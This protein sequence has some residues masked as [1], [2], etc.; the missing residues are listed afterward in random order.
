MQKVEKINKKMVI[1]EKVEKYETNDVQVV[2]NSED[3]KIAKRLRTLF[4]KIASSLN[5][6]DQQREEII[7]LIVKNIVKRNKSFEQIYDDTMKVISKHI[8]NENS[9]NYFSKKFRKLLRSIKNEKS[10]NISEGK[11]FNIK[12]NLNETEEKREEKDK[13]DYIK[14]CVINFIDNQ[15]IPEVYREISEYPIEPGLKK[16]INTFINETRSNY[17]QYYNKDN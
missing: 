2:S 11:G 16:K 5:I 13:L 4:S 8:I 14:S 6:S 7:N 10:D 3:E 15:K 1:R 17:I 9:K 12:I